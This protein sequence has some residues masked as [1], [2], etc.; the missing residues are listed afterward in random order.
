MLTHRQDPL[1]VSYLLISHDLG[2]NHHRSDRVLVMK[3]GRVVERGSADDIFTRPQDSY[4]QRLL[5][6]LPRLD[7]AS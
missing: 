4:T 2:V 6:A 7:Q 3:D 1:A 5:T